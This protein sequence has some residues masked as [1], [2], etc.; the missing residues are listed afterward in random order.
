M[1]GNIRTGIDIVEIYRIENILESKGER[2]LNKIFTDSE[3]E[4]IVNKGRKANTVAGM[5]ATKEA[6][7]KVLGSGIGKINWKDIELYHERSGKPY[8]NIN[9]K[10]RDKFDVL[11]IDSIDISISHEKKYAVSIA[12]GVGNIKDKR[13][14]RY[15]N[16]VDG[17]NIKIPIDIKE[18]LKSRENDTH[19]GSYGRV[20]IIAGSSG[21]TGAPY[22][23]CQ[24]AL[25]TGSGLVYSIVP[26][27]IR[28]IMSIKLTEVIVKSVDDN[29]KGYFIRASLDEILD[30]IETMDVVAIGPGI[31]VDE[32]RLHI[33][34]EIIKNYKKPIILDADAINCLSIQHNILYNRSQE[35]IITPHPGELGRFLNKTISEIQDNRIYY[36]KYAAN[37]YNI[38][39]VLKGSGTVVASPDTEDVYV[40]TT[41]NPG[42]ATA[43]SG[44]LLT[45]MISSFVGQGIK[46]L[47]ASILSVFTHGLA[48]DLAKSD[49]GEQ[50]M[51]ASDILESIPESIRRILL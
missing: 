34:E 6:V 17:L 32:D 8:I 30:Y 28:E 15:V 46:P 37:K 50:G 45:G 11:K 25:R 49:K 35:I 36:A 31:G 48:G 38:I 13:E 24:A 51:I 41:G 16:D 1:G 33:I 44:D 5:F 14:L 43:G 19:K 7:S 40:N 47:D 21:M 39:V 22:L 3:I 2:F 20:G 12:I 23:S 42:M 4:Y 10:I 18:I 29:K 9:K 26:G 27:S